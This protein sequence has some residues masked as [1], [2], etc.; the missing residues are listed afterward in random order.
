MEQVPIVVT[1]S[2]C[3]ALP[4]VARFTSFDKMATEEKET[5]YAAS[6]AI[7]APRIL[8]QNGAPRLVTDVTA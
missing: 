8:W 7:C 1:L 2:R 4:D 3:A 5:I 6:A